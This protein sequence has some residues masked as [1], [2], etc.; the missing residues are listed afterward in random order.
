MAESGGETRGWTGE[1]PEVSREGRGASG[2]ST[3]TISLESVL[4]LEPSSVTG[5][6]GNPHK[7]LNLSDSR[8]LHS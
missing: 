1:H 7:F 6:L 4:G 5:R 8:F 2:C 3:S